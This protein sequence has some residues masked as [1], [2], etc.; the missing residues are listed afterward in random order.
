MSLALAALGLYAVISYMV[1]QRRQEIGIR[2]A[3]ARAPSRSCAWSS[4]RDWR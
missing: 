1:V 4:G 2:M 3:S